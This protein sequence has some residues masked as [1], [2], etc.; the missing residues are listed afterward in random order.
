MKLLQPKLDSYCMLQQILQIMILSQ[1]LLRV[2]G[3]FHFNLQHWAETAEPDRG[4]RA[5]SNASAAAGSG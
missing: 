2:K 5:E 3:N 4:S 1:A